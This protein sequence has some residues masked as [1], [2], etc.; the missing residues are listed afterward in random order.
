MKKL[1]WIL[2][3]VCVFAIIFGFIQVK[4]EADAMEERAAARV[5]NAE[6]EENDILIIP[7]NSLE[8]KKNEEEKEKEPEDTL[9]MEINEEEEK[10]KEA[11][12]ANW[13]ELYTKEDVIAAAKLLWGEARGVPDLVIGDRVISSECQQAAV[14]WTVL[15][16][17]DAGYGDSVTAVITAPGQYHG[18][19]E[20]NPVDSDLLDLTI[21]VLNRWTHEKW[22][23]DSIGRVLPED[24][25]WFHG[26]GTHNYFRNEF[27]SNSYWTW[28][29]FDPYTY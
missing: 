4:R 10:E 20:S 21:D 8:E 7:A 23:G 25:M 28:E 17:Y 29:L 15:N 6:K 2:I 13:H 18:Y 16:R 5:V 26:D 11:K 19:S 14:L 22:D 3:V 9:C 12:Y 1:T 24:Y 27:E